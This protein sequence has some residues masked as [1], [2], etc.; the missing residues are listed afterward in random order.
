MDQKLNSTTFQAWKMKFLKSMTFHVFHDLYK[1]CCLVST[2]NI[3][4]KYLHLS[5]SVS[6]GDIYAFK[7]S[8]LLKTGSYP[9]QS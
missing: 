2:C 6:E 1:P 3:I 7:C 9:R 4:S 8:Q 5:E